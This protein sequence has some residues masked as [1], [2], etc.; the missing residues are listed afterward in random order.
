M[1]IAKLLRIPILK[2]H[3]RKATSGLGFFFQFFEYF[4]QF[5]LAIKFE[6]YYFRCFSD[7]MSFIC[8]KS[9]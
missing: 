5:L 8:N 9:S 4:R 6:F 1:N 7:V 2:K 3:L